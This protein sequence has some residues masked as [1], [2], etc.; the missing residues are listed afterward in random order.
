MRIPKVIHKIVITDDGDIPP[1]G[2][3]LSAAVD[4]WTQK[5]EGYTVKMYSGKACERYIAEHFTQE[6]LD[7][8][9]TLKPYAFRADY[10]RQLVLL[11][12]G[13]WYSDLRQV[14]LEPLD[15]LNARGKDYYCCTDCPPNQ[16]CM[17]NAFIGAVPDHPITQKYIDLIHWN[18]A[19]EHYGLDC[20]YTTGPG[21]F[22]NAAIDHLR[23]HMNDCFLG[24]HTSEECIT[25]AGTP[26]VKCK[27]N[28]AS[29]ADNRDLR[30]S[31][32]YG[33]MW[34]ARD[35]YDTSRA[36]KHGGN[37]S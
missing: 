32:N 28:N 25:F 33:H 29:G 9:M 8:Y 37:P 27:Y 2:E 22:M 34:M 3:R 13:G 5:N 6:H 31:N 24:S 26:I 19:H 21:V 18:V 14:C 4:T 17:Y 11:R 1:F 35:V 23:A 7:V 16:M 15:A 10:F 30:G 20:L 12:E 36:R